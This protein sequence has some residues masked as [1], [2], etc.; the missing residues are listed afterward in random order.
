LKGEQPFRPCAD[1]LLLRVRLTPRAGRDAIEGFRVGP[2]GPHLK[3][4]VRAV[5]EDGKA[6]AALIE[7][8]AATIG[9]AKSSL[10]ISTGASSR[11]KTVHIAGDTKAL[12]DRLAAWL[13]GL[14]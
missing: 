13:E 1:G 4:R 8:L 9:L 14:S 2:D 7:L 10:S 5:P 3:V 11:L 6:N 12:T